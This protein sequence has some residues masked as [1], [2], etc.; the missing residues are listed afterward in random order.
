MN[1][2]IISITKTVIA[3][4]LLT[5]LV[6]SMACVPQGIN[7]PN[8]KDAA[9]EVCALLKSKFGA[10]DLVVTACQGAVDKDDKLDDASIALL[11]ANRATFKT[12]L[13]ADEQTK[14]SKVLDESKC[15]GGPSK[16]VS[17][18]TGAGG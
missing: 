17:A 10:P 8:T 14:V 9:K 7:T 12:A 1:K 3:S 18:A 2:K 13:S 6:V 5:S 15:P 11:C 16:G 4:G